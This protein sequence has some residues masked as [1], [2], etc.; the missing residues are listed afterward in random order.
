MNHSDHTGLHQQ[1]TILRVTILKI[2]LPKEG[3]HSDVIEEPSFG[4]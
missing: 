1:K 2:K 4:P 3:Y